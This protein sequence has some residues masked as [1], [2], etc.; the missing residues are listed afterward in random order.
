[1]KIASILD[2]T[3]EQ[4]RHVFDVNIIASF[5]MIKEFLPAMIQNNHGHII[6][7]SSMASFVTGVHNVDYACSKI[8][9]LALHE[10]LA[11]ELRHRY[12]AP[13]VR[14]R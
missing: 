1:M 4:I 12:K 7:I 5:L 9:T 8:G 13:K 14:T 2:E 10:G 6:T 3:E 11:Q